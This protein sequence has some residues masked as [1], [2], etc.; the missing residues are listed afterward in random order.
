[1]SQ[2]LAQEQNVDFHVGAGSPIV[3]IQ[4]VRPT[5]KRILAAATTLVLGLL[6]A[7]FYRPAQQRLAAPTAAPVVVPRS[8]VEPEPTDA[9]YP[10]GL[11]IDPFTIANFLRAHPNAKLGPLWRRLGIPKENPYYHYE[12]CSYCEPNTFE[13]NLDNDSAMEIVL[14]I[15]EP[16]AEGVY[17]LIFKQARNG[18]TKLIGHVENWTKYASSDPIAFA[19]NGHTW[20]IL[21]GTAATGSGLG[22]WIDTVYEV[23]GARVK[24]MASYLARVSQAGNLGFPYKDFVAT[25]VSA[26]LEPGKFIL[27][28][29]CKVE[30]S[31][32]PL[33]ELPL[34][35][36]QQKVVLVN[37]LKD[38]SYQVDEARSEMAAV[39][40]ESVCDYE[41]RS[42]A[43][44]L[45]YNRYELFAIARE[46]DAEKKKWLREFL[47]TCPSYPVKRE[48]LVA[49]KLSS[50]H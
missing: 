6:L 3:H 15:K 49:L 29:S 27:T 50:V 13:F 35:T 43:D 11:D 44:F 18:D 46:D 20:L 41:S 12:A 37:L 48:L 4:S 23:S 25:P 9:T 45:R 42:E 17:Y 32:R 10:E 34:F 38:R 28:L 2:G 26:E 22:A 19:S 5:C 33:G 30:Y 8:A 16:F 24:P 7:A 40:F 1:M 36:K 21:Q 47:D 31:G 39:E 14:Q